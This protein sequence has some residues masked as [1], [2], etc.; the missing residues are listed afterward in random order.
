[1]V[2]KVDNEISIVKQCKLSD[3]CCSTL[4]FKPEG[5]E[6]DLNLEIMAELDKQ[7]LL[8]PFYGR[9]KL[10]AHL[11]SLGINVNIK[12]VRRLMQLL[13]SKMIYTKANTSISNKELAKY[14]YLLKDL[15]ITHRN[16]VWATDITYISMYRGLCGWRPTI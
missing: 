2:E 4:Y 8:T 10:V 13:D 12:R 3:V 1:M 9:N 11:A 5:Q 15:I 16:Q 7:Y 6:S 14:P